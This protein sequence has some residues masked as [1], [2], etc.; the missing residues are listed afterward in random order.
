MNEQQIVQTVKQELSWFQRH[1]RIVLALIAALVLCLGIVKY[2]DRQVIVTQAQAQA[3]E[4]KAQLTKDAA[5]Q[6][7]AE[8]AQVEAQLQAM[9]AD[10]GAQNQNLE[11][12]N[13]SLLSALEQRKATDAQLTPTGLANRIQELSGAP[14]GSIQ[15]N[16]TGVTMT[17]PGAVAVAQTLEEV[18]VLQANLNNEKQIESNKDQE[19]AKGKE[20]IDAQAGQIAALKDQGKADA[21]ACQAIIKEVKAQAAKSKRHWFEA[22]YVAGLATRSII[23]LLMGF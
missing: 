21:N 7:A 17:P 18:P 8:S 16:T 13:K 12:A 23:K 2:Q 1:E 14:V 5:D 9:I 10:L 6:R 20:L 15:G 19:L 3:A 11:N 4:L 22:G